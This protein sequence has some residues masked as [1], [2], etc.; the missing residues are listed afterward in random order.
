MSNFF[1]KLTNPSLWLPCSRQIYLVWFI[2]NKKRRGLVGGGCREWGGEEDTQD[3]FLVPV[4]IQIQNW[5][6]PWCLVNSKLRSAKHLE[7]KIAQ[8]GVC[9]E[10]P[11]FQESLEPHVTEDT[12]SWVWKTLRTSPQLLSAVLRSLLC[13]VCVYFTS[14]YILCTLYSRV[15]RFCTKKK[16]QS[17]VVCC[18]SRGTA[19]C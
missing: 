14:T 5:K 13:G 19:I 18:F 3:P 2:D 8:L 10:T 15:G 7:L 1:W 17:L 6:D 11:S 16:M 9:W 4:T 12:S